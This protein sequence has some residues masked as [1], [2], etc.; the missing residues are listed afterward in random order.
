MRPLRP[1]QMSPSGPGCVKTP[2]RAEVRIVDI[3]GRNAHASDH[4]GPPW[5]CRQRFVFARSM[6]SLRSICAAMVNFVHC[7]RESNATARRR[8][9][10]DADD[11]GRL[12]DREQSGRHRY[13][14]AAGA[15]GAVTS[16]A[17]CFRQH[18]NRS[19]LRRRPPSRC[20]RAETLPS[21]VVLRLSPPLR[22]ASRRALP[23]SLMMSF[24]RLLH[25]H[26]HVAVEVGDDPDGPCDDEKDD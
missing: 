14:R 16:R 12:H 18:R 20:I 13:S 26:R 10:S 24:P 19:R 21:F 23:K 25:R 3:P 8:K 11:F 22:L 15:A 7:R 9:A 5:F 6:I 1:S 2:R 17:I 4:C